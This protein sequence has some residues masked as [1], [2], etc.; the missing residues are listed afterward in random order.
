M[1]EVRQVK[2]WKEKRDF[3]NFPLKLYEDNPY[4]V[5]PL[6]M[7]EKK[8]FRKDYVYYDTCEAVYYNAYDDGKMVGRISGILQSAANEKN[9]EKRIRFTRFDAVDRPEVSEALFKAVE[10][11]GRNKGMEYICGP[12]GFSDLEREGL[13]IDGF[14]QLA[15][16]EEQYNAPYYQE[17]IEKL[18]YEKEVDWFESKVRP[19]KETAAEMKKMSEFIMKRYHLHM[20]TARNI[21]EFLEKYAD[22]FFELLEK[23][24]NKI[25]GTVPF[26]DNMKKMMI[27]NFKLII[28]LK[29]VGVV[30][31]ENEK[32]VCLG[33]CFPSLSKAVQK[34]KGKL[35]PAGAVR[36]LRAANH[37]EIIDLGLI[38]V[39]PEWENRG[40]SIVI[41][42]LL[43]E[44][45][46]RE[47]IEHAE[48]NLNLED[49]AA[50][51]NLWKQRFDSEEHKKRRSYIK[52]L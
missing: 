42:D 3:L 21:N 47:E 38:G 26:T 48:T 51:R 31:D 17:H 12:L 52:K 50:I 29:Y 6:Y 4:F 9:H 13:L 2:S 30:L 40:V 7:D 45:L 22:S 28:K 15:T 36:I 39:D 43:Y 41:A 14:D 34:S 11:W 24:Y 10:D 27:D 46:T 35:T 44:M 37:A 32:M 8:V 25:Y 16:F 1:I 33:L 23:S 5:P 20:G 49:S 18:G 19:K